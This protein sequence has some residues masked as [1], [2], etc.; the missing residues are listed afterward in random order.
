MLSALPRSPE[1]DAPTAADDD[2]WFTAWRE[3]ELDRVRRAGVTYLDFTG[4]ALYPESLVRQDAERLAGTVLGNPHSQHGP[5]RQAT[6]DVEA[7]R[8]AILRF[9]GA[10]PDDHTVVLAA[11]ASGACR[12]VGESFPFTAS[13][14]LALSADNHNSVNGLREY[15]LARGAALRTLS[16]DDELRLHDPVAELGEAPP[17]PSLLAFPAQSNF[18]GVRHPLS[19]VEEARDRGWRVLLDAASWLGSAGLEVSGVRPDFLCLSIYKIAGY[20]TGI[21][22]LVARRDALDELRRPSFAGGT[23]QWVSVQHRRHRLARGAEGFEDGTAPFLAAGAVPAALAAARDADRPRLARHLQRLTNDLLQGLEALRTPGARVHPTVHG[24]AAT[25]DRGPTVAITLRDD[26]GETVPWW[27][28]EEA[29]RARG[30]AIRGGCFCNPGCAE[31]AFGLG[32]AGVLSCL[33][34]LDDDFTV[35]AFADC[36]GGRTPVGAV[37]VSLGCGSVRADVQ[38]FLEFLGERW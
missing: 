19:L 9:V 11:N 20:P 14:V 23:V 13:S 8:D 22:A 16:L 34:R 31:R 29:A 15:A 26:R 17:G 1:P 5:S 33:E 38:R 4:A 3:R 2:A 18:S 12:L 24:P 7:A 35:P 30:I 27:R 37:R 21:G 25:R 36:L 28:V 10:D 6:H 32:D